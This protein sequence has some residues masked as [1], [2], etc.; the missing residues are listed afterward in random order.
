M[1]VKKYLG[2]AAFISTVI[3]CTVLCVTAQESTF[4]DDAF[5]NLK[6]KAETFLDKGVL[7]LTII[8]QSFENG[9]KIPNRL[10][11][12]I[13]E[14]IPPDRRRFIVEKKTKN[15]IERTEYIDI[16][17]QRFVKKNNSNWEIFK[18]EGSGVGSGSGNGGG[19]NVKIEH[20]TENKLKRGVIINNQKADYYETK[21]T[22]KYIYP[23]RTVVSYSKEGFWFDEK[24]RY[25]KAIEEGFD[26]ETKS[27]SQKTTE[28]EY[29][30]KIK[31]EAP[32]KIKE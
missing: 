17:N 6:E 3:I 32:I 10:E 14:V 11:K 25:V 21:T 5:Y 20:S 31:I 24:G 28:Y 1:V 4:D 15:G 23:T 26:E 7:R 29:D 30:P 12:Y 16:A 13:S 19:E 22:F 27:L 18:P 9:S 2:F 8:E